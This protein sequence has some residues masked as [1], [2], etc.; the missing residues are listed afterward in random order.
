MST[1]F[2][3]PYAFVPPWLDRG[4]VAELRDKPPERLGRLH[5]GRWSGRLR[6]RITAVTPLLI[7]EQGRDAA[8]LAERGTRSVA[9]A[10]LLAS[11]S[12]KGSVRSEFETVTGSRYGVFEGHERRLGYR[13]STRD[14]SDLVPVRIMIVADSKRALRLDGLR[15]TVAGHRTVLKAA[16]V[17]RYGHRPITPWPAGIVHG[18]KCNAWV[19]LMRRESWNDKKN[20][21]VENFLYWRVLALWPDGAPPADK[22]ET[23]NESYEGPKRRHLVEDPSPVH[24]R[25]FYVH[26]N[27]NVENK[28]DER[29]FFHPA[30]IEGGGK[31]SQ[32]I[33]LDDKVVD[34]WSDLLASY[35][36]AH[37]ED[38]IHG[39]RRPDGSTAN[40]SDYLRSAKRDQRDRP[41]WSRHL[42]PRAKALE[43]LMALPVDTLC[44]A[45]LTK[46]DGVDKVEQLYP[47]ALS[48][49][50]DE[51]SP[52]SLAE[53]ARLG[54]AREHRTLSPAD[55]VFGWVPPAGREAGRDQTRALRGR[56]RFGPVRTIKAEVEKIDRGL[57]VLGA[58]R[59][60][61][62]LFY[63]AETTSGNPLQATSGHQVRDGYHEGQGLRGRKVYPHQPSIDWNSRTRQQW[64]RNGTGLPAGADAPAVD[65]QNARLLDWVR[66]GAVFEVDL[67]M[68]DLDAV[69]LGALLYVLRG[70]PEDPRTRHHKLGG[71]APL[72][73][74]SVTYEVV[75]E[76]S[77]LADGAAWQDFFALDEGAPGPVTTTVEQLDDLGDE[78]VRRVAPAGRLPRHL[79]AYENALAG[80]PQGTPVRYPADPANPHSDQDRYEWF[81]ANKSRDGQRK[82]LGRLDSDGLADLRLPANPRNQTNSGLGNQGHPRRG[83]RR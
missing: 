60:T 10:P 17:P 34:G 79:T 52:A 38:A 40:A 42:E 3:N 37:T 23:E 67:H 20:R 55:R 4:N 8:G 44:Y 13:S 50:L 48:R 59:P 54:P 32:P 57:A 29:L 47:V 58:P 16:W 30:M 9:G 78:F 7:T 76:E 31:F 82:P 14:S 49:V 26:T 2:F 70:R 11:S 5:D 46:A 72:G 33:A 21:W 24:I 73:F 69:E 83:G 81:V 61:Q 63:A 35:H 51:V 80:F 6:L 53:Q 41:A 74:G 25:G 19:V 65:T 45:K 39:R 56:V 27:R 18:S 68:E 66:D 22:P 64:L 36:A 1:N 28:H 62:D 71:G 12:V 77:A 75:T 43:A 15:P